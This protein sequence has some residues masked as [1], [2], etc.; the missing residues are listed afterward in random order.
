MENKAW[1]GRYADMK[2]WEAHSA[3][4]R[5]KHGVPADAR[6]WT[7]SAGLL[8]VP[9]TARVLDLL[10]TSFAVARLRNPGIARKEIVKG[11]WANVSQGVQRLPFA[12]SLPTAATSTWAYS[13]E[14]D[15][16]LTA[17]S[18]MRMQGWPENLLGQDVSERDY[19]FLSGNGCSVPIAAVLTS[20]LYTNP[21]AP[22]H[23]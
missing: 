9:H 16:L 14:M 5:L 12:W 1:M 2:K 17:R 20:I 22:W 18:M 8:G 23:T 19:R 7:E 11:L 21:W 6:P 3:E 4:T 15:R 13:Y 10:D